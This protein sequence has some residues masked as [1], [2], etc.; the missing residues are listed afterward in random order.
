VVGKEKA[1][2]RYQAPRDS[3]T[4][5]FEGYP[6]YGAVHDV[7][8]N[9]QL[10][11]FLLEF[12]VISDKVFKQAIDL[13]LP[14]DFSDELEPVVSDAEEPVT[15]EISPED[16][17]KLKIEDLYDP[18]K[19]YKIFDVDTLGVSVLEMD[20]AARH[21]RTMRTIWESQDFG[22]VEQEARNEM[23]RKLPATAPRLMFDRVQG[24]GH[25]LP[26]VPKTEVR[27]KLALMPD[28]EKFPETVE[29][30]SN[31]A[32][33]IIEEV[34]KRLKQFVYP[35]DIV[36]H[37]TFAVFKKPVTPEQVDDIVKKTNESLKTDPFAVRLGDLDFRSKKERKKR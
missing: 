8:P 12:S 36:P 25:R 13:S 10:R 7:L 24:V 4:R 1:L 21:A 5:P 15:D 22:A 14:V 37:L 29:F 33:I 11:N 3:L 2:S 6:A 27:Q 34:K 35:W 30:I 31:E 9:E 28:P 16:K 17:R 23:A 26:G 32:D 19:N 18:R 20:P